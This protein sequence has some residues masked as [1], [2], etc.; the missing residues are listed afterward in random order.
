MSKKYFF[1]YVFSLI[2]AYTLNAQNARFAGVANTS[3]MMY[4]VW[5]SMHNQ[6]GLSN[7]KKINIAV[8][9]SNRFLMSQTSTQML[10]A[11]LPT[12]TGNFALSI[13]RFGYSLYSENNIGLAYARSL[14]KFIDIGVQ[15]DYLYYLQPE[16]YGNKGFFLLETGIIAK[17]IEKLFIG[18]HIYNPIRTQLAEYNNERVPT[19]MRLGLGYYFSDQVMVNIETEKSIEQ[20]AR[21]KTGIE[22]QPI[23]KLYL[24]TGFNTNPIQFSFGAGYTLKKI[25]V[26]MA[27]LTH[28]N[29][30]ITSCVSVK[31]TF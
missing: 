20:K 17:P 18:V 21:F 19:R 24:R 16:N 26:D 10:T 1:T 13:K 12:K 8:G 6:A 9:Y 28:Q 15:F 11:V 4:D 22:Y 29:L 30:P 25:T 5:S 23:E 7:I 31:Y 2:F 3:V 14:G 27:V